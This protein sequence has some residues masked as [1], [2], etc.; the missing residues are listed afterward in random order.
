MVL[1]DRLTLG[2]CV[3][4]ESGFRIIFFIIVASVVAAR[5]CFRWKSRR[6]G[7]TGWSIGKAAAE[8]EG[9]AGI[10]W[11]LLLFFYMI[12]VVVIY[13]FKPAWLTRFAVPL[14]LWSRWLGTGIAVAG[15]S[16]LVW[17]H[18]ALGRQWSANLE[19]RGEHVL[20]TNGPYRS[21][22]HPMY[23]SFIGLAT[24]LALMS[25]SWLIVLL[26]AM[27]FMVLYARAGKEEAMMI[28]NLG[29]EY[30]AYMRCTGRLLPRFRQHP[31]EQSG[32]A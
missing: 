22:R 12:A 32:G 7:R 29:D 25:A 1:P 20:I 23:C 10:L 16:L 30:R 13:A 3:D 14:P 2:G 26:A 11:R 6:A 19:L 9:K 27:T 15:L 8:R 21:V 24:G 28:E 18:H 4:S 5:V 17:T 31:V